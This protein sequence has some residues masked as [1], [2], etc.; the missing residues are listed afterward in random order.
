[1]HNFGFTLIIWFIDVTSALAV[2]QL[3]SV[4]G[5]CVFGVVRGV[6]LNGKRSRFTLFKQLGAL[7][8]VHTFGTAFVLFLLL[9]LF[10]APRWLK[11]VTG[12]LS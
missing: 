12:P 7:A 4:L 6:D 9:F 10:G 11:A 3:V 8:L 2:I 1:M 5:T